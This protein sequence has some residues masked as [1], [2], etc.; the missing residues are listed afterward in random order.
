MEKL[1]I[2]GSGPAGLT[3]A[4]YS[5]R[6]N[7]S[8]L[9]IE[10]LSSGGQLMTTTEVENFP[11]FKDPV[12]GPDLIDNMRAQAQRF[13]T[14][15]ET[16]DII[17]V[18]FRKKPFTLKTENKIYQAHSVIIATGATPRKLNIESET[19]LWGHGVSSC[20]TCDGAFFRGKEITVIGG[21]DSALEEAVFL[22]RFA[23]KVTLVHRRDQLRAS[24]IM[25]AKAFSN[26]KIHFLWDSI[27]EEIL[28][29]EKKLVR[30]LRVKNLK[31]NEV[32]DYPCE[33]VF[34]AI[35][36]IPNTNLFEGQ[37][38]M[39]RGYIIVNN[40]TTQ[41]NIEGIFAA[42][43]AVDHI[44][45]QA[46]TASAMGCKAAIDVERYLSEQNI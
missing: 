18:D 45:R 24:K 32:F 9:V 7:L 3:A 41:T 16:G 40:P 23:S 43:D 27:I 34:I 15:F 20:A 11:G 29:N 5:G 46:I 33:G 28:S 1:I 17:E 36:H 30:G 26:N 38:D 37:I 8:P 39:D 2:I 12:L 22:T 6:A 10:G 25:Q 19:R 14:R 42:G 13:G 4:I 44:Y 35:G 21:G 31:T